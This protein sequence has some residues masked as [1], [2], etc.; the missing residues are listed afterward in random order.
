MKEFW[1]DRYGQADFVYGELPNAYLRDKLSGLTPGKAL[2][3][4][5][6]EGRN[7]VYAATLGWDVSA[8]DQ[9]EKGREKA[10][11]LA[12]KKGVTIDYRVMS[13]EDVDYAEG[14]FD[15]LVLIYAH[16]SAEQRSRYYKQFAKLLKPG[17]T[18]IVEGF[19]KIH[20]VNQQN[21]PMAGGPRNEE[22][23]F[24]L[25]ELKADFADFEFI[26]AVDAAT[27]LAE[28]AYHQGM[29]AVVRIFAKK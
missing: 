10:M 23:L 9:S 13:A 2:F 18:L 22:M 7:A 20:V 17:G 28:G 14:E 3:A 5:E 29:A 25:D 21:N 16:F 19:S 24:D 4:A 12:V 1:N 8:F 15:L 26:D 27:T 11:M 6:G